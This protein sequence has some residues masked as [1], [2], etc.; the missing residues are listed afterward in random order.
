MKI[1]DFHTHIFPPEIKENREEYLKKDALFSQLY[2]SPRARLTT[3]EELVRN[4]D[5]AGIEISVVLNL[6]WLSHELCVITNDYIMETISRYSGRLIGFGTVTPAAGDASL[7][8]LERCIKGGIRGIGEI[9]PS[10][11]IFEGK[12]GATL[13]SLAQIARAH[14]LIVL[15]HSSEPVGHRYPGKGKISPGLL[16]RLASKYPELKIICAHWGGGLAFYELMP[17]VSEVLKNTCYDTAASTLLYK[18]DIFEYA[19][20]FLPPEKIVFGSDF[21]LISPQKFIQKI[22]ALNLPM[23]KEERLFSGNAERFLAK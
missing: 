1:I 16:Y 6:N 3:A 8:E 10:L 7:H 22:K 14:N 12:N 9:R 15:I 2:S 23:E 18:M 13:D 21:P 5:E 17:E 4:M 20:S 19:A 11:A